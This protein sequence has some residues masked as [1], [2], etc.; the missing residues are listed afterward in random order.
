MLSTYEAEVKG[1]KVDLIDKAELPE[2]SHVLVTVL[3]EP[4]EHFWRDAARTSMDA[5]WGNT[6]DDV[7]AALLP[8]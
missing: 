4:D 8:K 2:G 5:I 6:E 3:T 1:G 7:Y